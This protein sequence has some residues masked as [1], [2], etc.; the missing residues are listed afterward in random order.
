MALLFSQQVRK[1]QDILGAFVSLPTILL[2]NVMDHVEL[3][4]KAYIN[5]ELRKR[6]RLVR[7]SDD[8]KAKT[9]EVLID[10]ADGI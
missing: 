3:D 4:M 9:I 2:S 5:E 6:S 10:Q 7:L 8:L 1:K